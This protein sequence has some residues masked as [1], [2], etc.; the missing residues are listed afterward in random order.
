MLCE[1]IVEVFVLVELGRLMYK[2]AYTS[3][4]FLLGE[5]QGVEVDKSNWQI[6]NFYVGLTDDATMRMG[7]KRP[8]FG[9]VVVCL[10]VSIVKS[11]EDTAILSITRDELLELKECK[12]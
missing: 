8:F 5:V 6:T 11:F 4:E 2:K 12:A 7:F 10:P 3:D 1:S 9:R